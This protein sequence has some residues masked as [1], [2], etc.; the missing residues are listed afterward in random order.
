LSNG[1]NINAI[2]K[3]GRN[4]VHY[5][6]VPMG[7]RRAASANNDPIEV[8]NERERERDIYRE[9][10]RARLKERGGERERERREKETRGERERA[11]NNIT[12]AH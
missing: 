6:F 11:T 10:E 3:C 4:P 12:N 1:A 5:V 7:K 2:D 8:G 9:R